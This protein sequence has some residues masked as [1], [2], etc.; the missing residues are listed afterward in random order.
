MLFSYYE[1]LPDGWAICDFQDVVD[2]E[3]PTEYL[4]D[5]TDYNPSYKTPVL[6]AGKSFILGYTNEEYGIFNQVPVIIF[7]D[8]TTESK[9]VDFPF[10]AKSSAMKILKPHNKAILTK[11]A[12]YLMQTVE[13][14]NENHQRYW[15]STF[16]K[17]QIVLPPLNEQK[18]IIDAIENCFEKLDNMLN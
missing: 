11:Y 14:D 7:D 9:Y 4:V 13:I 10:K 12:Y 15:I 16:S 8:F 2:Y 18:R 3:Q 1:K 6:T 17:I 5:S